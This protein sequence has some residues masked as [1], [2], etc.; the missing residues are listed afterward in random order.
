VYACALETGRYTWSTLVED[1][2]LTVE[3]PDGSAW[4]PRNFDETF[5]G[6]VPLC[7]A[8]M[9]SRNVPTVRVGLDV[10]VDAVVDMLGR[11]GVARAFPA[12]PSFLLG[13]APLAPLEVAQLYNT[14]AAGGFVTPLRAVREVLTADGKPL[15]HFPL[16]L[17][18]ATTPEVAH[19]ITRALEATTEKGTA[20][21]L[22][23]IL[24]ETLRVAGKTGT[25]DDFRDSWF[26]GYSGDRVAVVWVGRDDNA[27]TGLTGATGALPLWGRLVASVAERGIDPPEPPGMEEVWVDLVTGKRTSAACE[28][29][30]RLP[31]VRG[32]A[33]QEKAECGKYNI[34][35]R[36]LGWFRDLFR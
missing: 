22:R 27:P 16:E 9:F 21:G 11:L 14:L 15:Q 25:T 28:H 30:V 29:A 20:K 17:R 7:Q 8:L 3:M 18:Q 26:A 24:P 34:A 12:Y 10:G 35:E 33:P 32:R 2:L 5:A 36:A 4:S 31:Y 19:Q 6:T 1:T 23:Q 13:A